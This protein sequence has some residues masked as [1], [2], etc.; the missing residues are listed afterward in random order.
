MV[1]Y[2]QKFCVLLFFGVNDYESDMNVYK[3]S[4]R[5]CK[6]ADEC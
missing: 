3:N 6:M 2:P 1:E 5:E 4:N